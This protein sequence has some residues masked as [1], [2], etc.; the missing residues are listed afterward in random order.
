MTAPDIS[1]L[2]IER[3]PAAAQ[4][5]PQRRRWVR[6]VIAGAVLLAIAGIA[7]KQLGGKINVETVTVAQS[8]PS[9]SYTLLNATG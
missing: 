3:N 8:Y 4:A 1:K 9:Q 5:R 6:P 2:K 7:S